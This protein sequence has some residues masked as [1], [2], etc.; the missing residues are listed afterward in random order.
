MFH[1]CY[2]KSHS[3]MKIKNENIKKYNEGIKR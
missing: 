1:F 3:K 2:R